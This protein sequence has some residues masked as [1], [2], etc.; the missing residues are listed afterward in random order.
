[1]ERLWIMLAGYF[2]KIGMRR[3]TVMAIGNLFL[4]MGISIFKLSGLGNDPFSGMVM[5]L[6]DRTGITYALFLV[7][8]NAVLFLYE[9]T[10]GRKLIGAGTLINAFLLGYI[11]TFFYDIWLTFIGTP[12][13]MPQRVIT[14]LTGVII[15]SFGVSLYQ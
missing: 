1:M 10:A 15:T 11:V 8:V 13:Q 3:F 12:E 6:S 4:G 5:A 2:K 7:M 14:V 9:I